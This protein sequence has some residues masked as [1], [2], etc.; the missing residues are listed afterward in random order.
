MFINERF[1]FIVIYFWGDRIW[2]NVE[3]SYLKLNFK[4]RFKSNVNTLR[5][6]LDGNLTYSPWT[7]SS[8]NNESFLFFNLSFLLC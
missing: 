5:V 8:F 3:F 2:I 6:F 7:Q 1:D 4:F